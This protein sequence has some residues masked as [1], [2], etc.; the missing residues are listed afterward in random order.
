MLAGLTF[1][2]A[3][4]LK[5]DAVVMSARF[6]SWLPICGI[7][8][9]ALG[10]LECLDA[11][12]AKD[13]R[14]F[15]HNLHVGILDSVVGTLIIFGVS[16]TPERLSLLIAAYLLIRSIVRMVL[17]LTLKLPH[18]IATS[19]CSIIS[20][21]MGLMIWMQWP[22]IEGWFLALC[23]SIEITFRGWTMITFAFWLKQQQ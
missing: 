20:I 11:L 5:S 4:A 10:L 2:L 6:F 3:S 1:A 19:I 22:T 14:E 8:I 21:A 9:L 15:Y 12:F 17:A 23:L 16:E 13:M 7:I 18:I